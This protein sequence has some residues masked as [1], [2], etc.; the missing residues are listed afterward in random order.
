MT[1]K[2]RGRGVDD[3]D[4]MQMF[5][6]DELLPPPFDKSHVDSASLAKLGLTAKDAGDSKLITHPLFSKNMEHWHFQ[7]DMAAKAVDENS[8][9]ILPTGLGKTNIAALVAA[10]R[11]QEK[12]HKKVLMLAPTTALVNQHAETFGQ[13][14]S[15][16]KVAK[17]MG[18]VENRE[19]IWEN[20]DIVIATPQTIEN[21][22]AGGRIK[23]DDVSLLIVDEAHKTRGDYSYVNVGRQY[24]KVEGS[25]VLGLTASPGSSAQKI[26]EICS[27]LGIPPGSIQI[28][29]DEDRDVKPYIQFVNR[30]EI[31]VPLPDVKDIRE[32]LGS[33]YEDSLDALQKQ[34]KKRG[35]LS[36]YLK[37][38]RFTEKAVD[39]IRTEEITKLFEQISDRK[40][41]LKSRGLD[42]TTDAKQSNADLTACAKVLKLSHALRTLDTHTL[43]TT[44]EYLKRMKGDGTKASEELFEDNRMDESYTAIGSMDAT[45]PKVLALQDIVL[46]NKGKN[47]LVFTEYTDTAED[48]TRELNEWNKDVKAR[49]FIGQRGMTKKEQRETLEAFKNR[50]FNV[51]VATSVAEEGLDISA[52]DAVVFFEPVPDEKRT[53]QR[54]GRTGRR[55][56]GEVYVLITEGSRDELN[57]WDSQRKWDRMRKNVEML[58]KKRQWESGGQ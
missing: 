1:I 41:R 35:Y 46:K 43:Y 23:L 2:R 22:L 3:P 45:H 32:Q 11:M 30:R 27:D 28:R 40:D 42:Y 26:K 12:P 13:L 21:D 31:K 14:F 24:Q 48:I 38:T 25:R 47:I 4:Q 5:K 9:I 54:A 57:Y 51:M 17:I 8:L 20:S 6:K 37:G 10:K 53:V 15:G 34:V 52:V 36:E 33:L 39:E 50:E 56:P 55:A 16:K 58:Q 18:G 19:K 44:Y 29:T 49:K 7:V